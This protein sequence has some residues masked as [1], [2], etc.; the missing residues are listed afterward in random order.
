[1][2]DYGKLIVIEGPDGVGKTTLAQELVR[3]L[4]STGVET[5]YMSFPG[6]QPGSLGYL[7]Y[8]LH[9]DARK[10]EIRGLPPVSLQLLHIAAHCDAITNKII[11][12]LKQGRNIVLDRY[13]WS[14]WVYGVVGKVETQALDLM[15]QVE[16]L[17]W[18]RYM[19]AIIYTIDRDQPLRHDLGLHEWNELRK[20]YEAL[21]SREM[22]KYPIST[23]QNNSTVQDALN[24]MLRD[25]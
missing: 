20:T 15:I 11:P 9:H 25:L 6:N 14:T 19:P 23:I 2:K 3:H 13:W 16:L 17:Y 10:F 1:M 7:V 5:D 21:R 12:V 22:E 24:Q 8:Q 4:K 18:G